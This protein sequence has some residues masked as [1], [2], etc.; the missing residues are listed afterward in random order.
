MSLQFSPIYS[1]DFIH[2]LFCSML[3]IQVFFLLTLHFFFFFKLG[4]QKVDLQCHMLLKATPAATTIR[5]IS[6]KNLMTTNKT[7]VL[8][9]IGLPP[10]SR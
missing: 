6:I 7:M 4:A 5:G 10:M 1:E 3:Y 9:F 2:I 8:I